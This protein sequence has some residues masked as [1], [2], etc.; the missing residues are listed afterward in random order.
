MDD[1]NFRHENVATFWITWQDSAAEAAI[2]ARTAALQGSGAAAQLQAGAC[3]RPCTNKATD[4]RCCDAIFLPS[5]FFQ[6]AFAFP[7]D[8]QIG[9]S[10]DTTGSGAVVWEVTVHALYFQVGRLAALRRRHRRLLHGLL[11]AS[12]LL[13]CSQ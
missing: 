2:A 8:R 9:Y 10:I 5:F 3:R 13:A 6:N 12:L 4:L 1:V 11:T 7:E